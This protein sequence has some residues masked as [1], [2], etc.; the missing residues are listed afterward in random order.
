V[1][2][3]QARIMAWASRV[4][5]RSALVSSAPSRGSATKITSTSLM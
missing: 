3:V 4:A 2:I 1:A 5:V